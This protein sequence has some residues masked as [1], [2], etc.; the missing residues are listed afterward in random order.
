[1]K[2]RSLILLFLVSYGAV[3]LATMPAQILRVFM[4]DEVVTQR[5]EGDVWRGRALDVEHRGYYLGSLSWAFQPMSLIT[6]SPRYRVS[7]EGGAARA[8]GDVELG[9]LGLSPR[10]DSIA[11]VS[12]LGAML[13]QLRLPPLIRGEIALSPEKLSLDNPL[14]PQSATRF[15]LNGITLDM[16][17]E[18]QFPESV[19]GTL[20][21]VDGTRYEAR[22]PLAQPE[23]RGVLL[24]EWSLQGEYRIDGSLH[25]ATP[26]VQASLERLLGKP[27]DDQSYRVRYRGR[28]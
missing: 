12:D 24:L 4:P 11:L 21:C 2:I 18:L 3:L 27:D 25:A 7:L 13:K 20:R 5:L 14:C 8:Q 16:L 15:S 9:F 17:P 22:I 6:L 1:M 10:A 23:L 19:E 26:P 28:W